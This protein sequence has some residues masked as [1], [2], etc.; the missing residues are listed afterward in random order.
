MSRVGAVS[1]TTAET[2]QWCANTYDHELVRAGQTLLCFENDG[3]VRAYC[4]DDER[5]YH[6]T[7]DAF[8]FYT[9]LLGEGRRPVDQA[10][11]A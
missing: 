3:Y 4:F 7:N 11:H 10:G 5:V 8:D 6:F 1:V 2:I 9:A